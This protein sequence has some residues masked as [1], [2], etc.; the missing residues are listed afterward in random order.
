MNVRRL[1]IFCL[2]AIMLALIGWF[3][4]YATVQVMGLNI[5]VNNTDLC[6]FNHTSGNCNGIRNASVVY[7]NNETDIEIFLYSHAQAVSQ[8]SD[9]ELFINGTM[10]SSVS[11]K[12]VGAAPEENNKSIVA[13]IPRGSY[14]EAHFTNFHHYEWREY[15]IHSGVGLNTTVNNYYNNT[16]G[17]GLGCVGNCS[18][19]TVFLNKISKNDTGV[20]DHILINA[21]LKN[22]NG[23]YESGIEFNHSYLYLWSSN[24]ILNSLF[25]SPSTYLFT[26]NNTTAMSISST[27]NMNRSAD[28]LG[29]RI[30]GVSNINNNMS[31]NNSKIH[32]NNDIG[33]YAN[34]TGTQKFSND[35]LFDYL[36][37]DRN[38]DN[39]NNLVSFQIL[40]SSAAASSN[41]FQGRRARGSINVS[42]NSAI[43]DPVQAGD[44]LY[45]IIGTGWNGDAWGGTASSF[46]FNAGS[47]N[48]TTS[49][50]PALIDVWVRGQTGAAYNSI[51]FNETGTLELK[52]AGKGITMLSPDGNDWCVTVTNAGALTVSSTPCT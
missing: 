36:M 13:I 47:L 38:T 46:I 50:M 15:Q 39:A 18:F 5:T 7:W 20:N 26:Q 25:L 44:R 10:M 27:I 2:L 43:I 12:P 33:Y 35:Y 1:F 37:A 24:T 21:T 42:N 16:T 41:I 52:T 23:I 4:P 8:T 28:M 34:S 19:D 40:T 17:G 31:F 45:Q 6:D 22:T 11:S 48:W 30:M 49:N 9:I 14:Y 3:L 29:N 32:F 51:R